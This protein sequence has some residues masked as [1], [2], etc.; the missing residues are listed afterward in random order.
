MLRARPGSFGSPAVAL[1]GPWPEHAEHAA[2]IAPSATG[3]Y[4]PCGLSA[5]PPRVSPPRARRLQDVIRDRP[6]EGRRV[7]DSASETTQLVLPQNANVHGTVL[8]G[9]V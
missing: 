3:T 5:A 9:T 6:R 7:S 4:T 2:A 1:G 8:G